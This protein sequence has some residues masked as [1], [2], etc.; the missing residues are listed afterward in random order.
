[1]S[2]YL[3]PHLST[4]PTVTWIWRI[5]NRRNE[6]IVLLSNNYGPGLILSVFHVCYDFFFSNGIYF[7][8]EGD[9]FFPSSSGQNNQF[10]E[11]KLEDIIYYSE[12]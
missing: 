11:R 8:R 2:Y 6:I 1:M 7:A 12:M 4:T 5:A 9:R 3:L 10:G